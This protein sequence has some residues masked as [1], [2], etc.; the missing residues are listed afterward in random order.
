MTQ[1]SFNP[2]PED[3][4]PVD[5]LF[6]ELIESLESD[7]DFDVEAFIQRQGPHAPALR[8]R[9]EKLDQINLALKDSGWEEQDIQT[10]G[11][12]EESTSSAKFQLT[13][14][15]R[16]EI[17]QTIADGGMGTIFRA[18]DHNLEREVA[19]KTI[20]LKA[21]SQ[22]S[23][24]T[25]AM[26]LQRFSNE[27]RITGLLEHPNIVPVHDLGLL[28]NG[29]LFFAMK[30]VAGKTWSAQRKE[31]ESSHPSRTGRLDRLEDHL[32]ILGKI[33]DAL[34]FAHQRGVIHRDLKPDNIM[35]GRFGEV[36]VMDWGLVK[37][38]E[39]GKG[40]PEQPPQEDDSFFPSN[41]EKTS[42]GSVFGTPAYM[43]PEQARGEVESIGPRTDVFG[44]G[45]L[46]YFALF[47]QAPYTGRNR[48]S[49]LEMAKQG[50]WN[51]PKG[52]SQTPF[53]LRAV[54]RKAMAAESGDR[55]ASPQAFAADL[56]AY[57][58]GL[59]GQAWQDS[60]V[61]KTLKSV[62]RHPAISIAMASLFLL[63]A[64]TW[65]M[66]NQ[67]AARQYQEN[68]NQLLQSELQW[69]EALDQYQTATSLLPAQ[70]GG[71]PILAV[72][73]TLENLKILGF[74]FQTSTQP[75]AIL[76]RLDEVRKKDPKLAEKLQL[77]LGDLRDLFQVAS[78]RLMWECKMDRIPERLSSHSREIV[79]GM[80][81]EHEAIADLWPT[82]DA[83]D[84]SLNQGPWQDE[85]RQAKDRWHIERSSDLKKLRNSPNFPLED[86]WQIFRFATFAGDILSRDL[87]HPDKAN[88][89]ETEL[90]KEYVA[91]AFA[92]ASRLAPHLF[93]IH[94]G[95]PR[96]LSLSGQKGWQEQAVNHAL[97]SVT[98]QPK[99]AMAHD[100]YAAALLL[101]NHSPEEA[102]F[103]A[104][105]AVRLDPDYP[106]AHN[107]LGEALRRMQKLEGEGGAIDHF[108][109]ALSLDPNNLNA[110]RNLGLALFEA[111]Q[112]EAACRQWEAYL[113]RR[114]TR[115]DVWLDCG[116]S[117]EELGNEEAAEACYRKAHEIH[118]TMETVDRW[119]LFYQ[120]NGMLDQ[121][122]PFLRQKWQ[123]D[124]NLEWLHFAAYL[125]LRAEQWQ[126]AIRLYRECREFQPQRFQFAF[127][128]AEALVQSGAYS[129]AAEIYDQILL[130][131]VFESR[132]LTFEGLHQQARGAA[133]LLE[134]LV[135]G[136]EGSPEAR[137]HLSD[138]FQRLKRLLA[139]P[140]S[141]PK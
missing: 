84:Q 99:S 45:A 63:A 91:E 138:T 19:V 96:L 43:A 48:Q 128:L 65:A 4:K 74:Q 40:E 137:E 14:S 23:P 130:A 121:V 34:A 69:Q 3:Q 123:E 132:A 82:V 95:A 49:I 31:W 136:K 8:Q 127:G 18:K 32:D 92:S 44:L 104:R 27:A 2:S 6:A 120:G 47:G 62:R 124:S 60:L 53:E 77:I 83:L 131:P 16:Y 51:F 1:S 109:I 87:G 117:Y 129:E 33:A 140:S 66:L 52:S 68:H 36:Q 119:M 38:L 85:L 79:R 56:K 111:N 9:L 103:Q 71:N 64:L 37:I 5:T 90:A 113:Q 116:K 118:P 46:L 141:K 105:E 78:L 108:E 93:W 122:E 54:C 80:L 97:Q 76:R 7:P 25:M 107:N 50:A 41:L 106:L 59:P 135:L 57:R 81:E 29:K 115:W 88:P 42:S 133:Q 17:L 11:E 13:P 114:P 100:R 12:Q 61:Q 112:F 55:Y 67:R 10:E 73:S 72:S 70:Y 101:A 98:L 20:K 35:I 22:S 134:P 89:E 39:S 75:E 110:Q 86:G 28:P 26:R 139:S 21:S 58:H 24:A 15:G 126:T 94:D 30:L 125:N 102:A